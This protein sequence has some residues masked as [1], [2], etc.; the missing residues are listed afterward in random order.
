MKGPKKLKYS[1]A[2][3]FMI[4]ALHTPNAVQLEL[5]GELMNKH[6]TCPLS[7]I[8]VHSSSENELFPLRKKPT[9][10]IPP[11]E[12]GVGKEII[13]VLEERTTRNKKER[14]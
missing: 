7:L 5:T 9:S 4:N 13:K 1:F 8:K 10:E 11:L 3:P 6:P 12:E 2:V 14:E